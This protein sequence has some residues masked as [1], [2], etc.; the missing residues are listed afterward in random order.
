M[1][2][3]TPGAILAI[4]ATTQFLMTL[5]T[6][7]M[8]VSI[9]TLVE[10]L[11]TS[12]TTV[13]GVIT[14][15]TLVMAAA[16][17]SGG[18][19][20]ALLGQRRALRI[21]LVVY[22]TGSAITAV[23]PNAAVLLIGWSIFE[24]LGAALIMPTVTA[25]VASNFDQSSRTRAYGTIAAASAVA[26][27]VGPIIGG[28][29]TTYASWRYVFVA[30]VLIAAGLFAGSRLV[31]GR[32][33]GSRASFDAGGAILSGIGVAL[34]VFAI[35]QSSSWG[36]VLP[37][38][39]E[40][41]SATPAIFGLSLVAWMLL[42]GAVTLWALMVW[43]RRRRRRG[44]D[45]LVD[46]DLLG[47]R[48]L[49]DGLI[50]LLLQFVVMMGM[51]FAM[52]LYLSIVLGLDAFQ[53]GLRLLPLSLALV[54]TAPLAPR[55]LRRVG[56]HRITQTGLLLM[57]IAAVV[58]ASRLD[59]TADAS[60]TLGPFVLM[61]VGMGLLGSQL[62]ALIVSAV[63]AERSGEVGGLQYTAQNLGAS[64]GTALIGALIVASLGTL[65]IRGIGETESL[66]PATQERIGIHVANGVDFLSDAQLE[67]LLRDAGVSPEERTVIIE[68]N[69]AARLGALR[70]AM[71][72]L[73]LFSLGALAFSSRLP[74]RPIA[75]LDDAA[76]AP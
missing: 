34:I 7:V 14:A 76:R 19:I 51:F 25:I 18:T 16:M 6:S 41:D 24:G 15:Y 26:I 30:E 9:A 44:R 21:G 23:A 72:A 39:S 10:D 45:P 43:L 74:R 66:A 69:S 2:R 11:D 3:R 38:V 22:G 71:F 5:D 61:G 40:G 53:T 8:N 35:L 65:L 4:L 42:A 46:P 52:P 56:V 59:A 64:I 67:V 50:V 55:L 47:A 31:D 1:G 57:A 62:G 49:T 58:L 27:A 37:R 36:W 29:A 48:R 73:A 70:V 28:L 32:R 54:I 12:V 68:E 63:P 60:I 33:D 75:D 20:G 13:Q 17:I